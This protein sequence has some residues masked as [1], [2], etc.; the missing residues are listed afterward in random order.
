M[1]NASNNWTLGSNLSVPAAW[2]S[3]GYRMDRSITGDFTIGGRGTDLS[4]YGQLASMVVT[5]LR[6]DDDMPTNAEI[7]EMIMDP[8]GWLDTYKVG[9]TFRHCTTDYSDYP[10][11]TNGSNYFATQVWLMGDGNND[12]YSNGIRNQVRDTDGYT[13]LVFNNMI[14]NDI[15][16]VSINGLT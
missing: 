8:M 13:K 6:T 16:T 11:D 14:S 1:N 15:Q 7:Q 4:F 3:T 10:W 12:S 2:T 5:T 9:S